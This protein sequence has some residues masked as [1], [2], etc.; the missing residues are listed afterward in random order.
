[1]TY[2]I[3]GFGTAGYHAVKAIRQRDPEGQIDVYCDTGMAPYNPMLTTYYAAGRLSYEGLFPYGSLEDICR[4]TGI[5]YI[6]ATV[7][8]V[9]AEEKCIKTDTGSQSYDRI[10]IATGARAFGPPVKG[11]G[12]QD[13]FFM[14]NVDDAQRLK[15]R[16]ASGTVKSALV[17]GASMVGIKVV[18][19][20]NKAGVATCLADL[21]EYIFPLA[22]YRDVGQA[23]QRR[24]E[25]QG[26]TLKFQTTVDHVE[27]GPQGQ[28]AIMT[29]GS[30][31]PSDIIVLCIGTRANVE[32][33]KD[34]VAINR[35]IIV[36]TKMETS[37]PGIYAA[38]DC[39]EG[40]NL[41]SGETQIIGLW[42]NANHQGTMAGTG[43]AGGEGAFEGNILHNITHFMDMDFIGFGDNRIQGD[44]LEFGSLEDGLFVRLVC[45]NGR[46]AGAN[47]LD[48]YRISGVIKNYML[49]LFSAPG[50][51]IPD[52]QRGML[53]KAG[54][55]EAFID[56]VE[57]KVYG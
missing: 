38:G 3:V 17:V 30:T 51:T 33:V 23:I 7:R 18:E 26:I 43:M 25:R 40:N 10:L 56:E 39:C 54:L 8:Q 12:E 45:A 16:M 11:A 6:A 1:M 50:Q 44:T 52:Y 36:N 27:Q 15:D 53:V 47:I 28:V 5:N 9:C 20:L 24:V 57:K 14:R 2:G 19:L 31:V 22:A 13:V 35:G 49:R 37:V 29:D 34:Q 55:P 32:L 48:N 21:A 41:Q 42:A 4:E 46:V